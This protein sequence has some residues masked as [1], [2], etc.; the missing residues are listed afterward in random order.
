MDVMPEFIKKIKEYLEKYKDVQLAL[1]YGSY[2]K[3]YEGMDSDLDIGVYLSDEKKQ[4]QIRLN[5][6]KISEKDIDIVLLNNA[7]AV[8]TSSIFKT[9]LPIVIKNRRLFLDLYLKQTLEAEDFCR[10]VESYWRIFVRSQSLLPEDKA[11]LITRFQFLKSEYSEIDD[12]KTLSFKEYSENKVKKRNLE[13]WTE[14]IINATLDI[15]KIVLA[16]EKKEV[17]KTY[18]QALYN[19]GLFINLKEEEAERLASFSHLRNILAHEYLEI[20]YDKIIE[21]IEN[22]VPIYK[23]IFDFFEK[24]L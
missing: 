7:P 5:L 22:S 10:F 15:A 17:P 14:N 21:F 9:G 8:L 23:K 16:S 12:F 4:N 19:F 2:A 11:R 20:I 24:Y 1:I 18:E 6:N 3:G 13:R